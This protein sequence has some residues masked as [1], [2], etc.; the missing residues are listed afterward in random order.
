VV[1]FLPLLGLALYYLLGVNIKRDKIFSS[2]KP[3]YHAIDE[4]VS[5][6]LMDHP[7]FRL[8]ELLMKNKSAT[9]SYDN[10]VEFLVNAEDTFESLLEVISLAKHSVY[11]EYYIIE[12]GVLFDQLVDR[13][14]GCIC[15]GVLVYLIYDEYGSSTLPEKNIQQLESIGVKMQVYMPISKTW[16]LKYLNYRNHRKIAII[17][18]RVSFIGGMNISDKYLN[19]HGVRTWKDITLKIIGPA[20]VDMSS[21]FKCDWYNA[22]GSL[23]ET[24]TEKHIETSGTPI[25]IVVGGPDAEYMGILHEYF[26]L[27][28]DAEAYVYILTP[29]FV[30]TEPI[31]TAI[32]TASLSGIDVR[33]ILPYESDSRWLKWCTFTYIKELLASGV[34]VYLNHDGFQH[35]K[36]ILCDDIVSSVGSANMDERS[37]TSNFEV[38]AVVYD[39][40]FT[41]RLK[42]Y[43]LSELQHCEELNLSSFDSRPD[44]NKGMEAIARLS[45]PIL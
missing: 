9:L 15:N 2:H 38:N 45:S 11:L 33:I 13:L 23:I 8:I 18:E 6:K 44:R 27:I 43:Y 31:V 10:Q 29:Y 41:T 14:S 17:D 16:T 22:G 4:R 42:N 30:P 39:S 1:I 20:A 37:F 5:P 35:G 25:Q 26:G 28:T 32:K 3:F 7:K 24:N 36:V 12:P 34:K 21:I 40:D 19:K